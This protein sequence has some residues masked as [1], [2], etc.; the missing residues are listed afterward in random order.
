M[1]SLQRGSDYIL[2]THQKYGWLIACIDYLIAFFAFCYIDHSNDIVVTWSTLEKPQKCF[3]KFG[4][5]N[6]DTTVIGDTTNFVDGGEEQRV[7]FM[8]K[9]TLPAL[10][11]DASYSK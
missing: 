7:I 8:H 1:Y 10:E 6:T 4:K 5:Q 2:H 11:Y 9:A 3:V